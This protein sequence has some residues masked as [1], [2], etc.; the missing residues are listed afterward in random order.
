[1]NLGR[2]SETSQSVTFVSRN[3]S[4]FLKEMSEKRSYVFGGVGRISHIA[5]LASLQS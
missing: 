3:N 1:M 5:L 4:Y 2:T